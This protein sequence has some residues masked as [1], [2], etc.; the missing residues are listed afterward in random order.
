MRSRVLLVLLLLFGISMQSR[1]QANPL[2]SPYSNSVFKPQIFTASGQTGTVIQLNGLVSPSS[3]VGSSFASLTATLTGTSL[4]TVTFAIQGSS[5]NG[6]TF[7]PLPI[8]LVASPLSPPSLTVTATANGLYQVNSGGLTHVRVVTSGTFT[9]TS[10]NLTLTGSPNALMSRSSSGGSGGATTPATTL[11]L[12]GLGAVNGVGDATPGVDY[13]IPSGNIATATAFAA[14]PHG[15][16]AGEASNTFD[17]SGN[18]TN[19]TAVGG[20]PGGSDTEVQ[21]N[22]LG[23]FGVD[24][25]FRNNAATHNTTSGGLNSTFD[26]DAFNTANNGIA[27]LQA[28]GVTDIMVPSGSTS[29]ENGVTATTVPGTHLQ[30]RTPGGILDYY[31]NTPGSQANS[32]T[33]WCA[34]DQPNTIEIQSRCHQLVALWSDA[35][36][37]VVGTPTVHVADQVIATA[38]GQGIHQARNTMFNCFTDD[39]CG[40]DYLYLKTRAAALAAASE[41]SVLSSRQGTEGYAGAIY[42][43]LSS[44]STATGSVVTL[45]AT[46]LA[47]STNLVDL[48]TNIDSGIMTG[49][50][51]SPGGMVPTSVTTSTSHAL[52]TGFGFLSASCGANE[53]RNNP[54]PATCP[55]TVGT[56]S[57]VT[58]FGSF[59]T[60]TKV[61]VGDFFNFECAKATTVA[62]GNITLMLS[63]SHPANTPIYQGVGTCDILIEGNGNSP[64]NASASGTF[65]TF[66]IMGA[67]SAN[68]WDVIY[69]MKN[70]QNGLI[71]I[72]IPA[73]QSASITSASQTG[74]TVTLTGAGLGFLN[75]YSPLAGQSICVSGVS[76]SAFNICGITGAVVTNAGLTLTYTVGTSATITGTGGVINVGQT[77]APTVNGFANY[78]IKCGAFVT[79][80]NGVTF[81][82]TS[83]DGSAQVAYNDCPWTPG[84]SVQDP[85]NI[86]QT[87]LGSRVS[88][89]ADTPPTLFGANTL[90]LWTGAHGAFSGGSFL[91]MNVETADPIGAF[92]NY[93][94]TFQAHTGIL[95]ADHGMG[96]LINMLH[97]PINTDPGKGSLGGA[98]A[99]IGLFEGG[100]FQTNYDLFELETN[101]GGEGL[102][103]WDVT[104]STLSLLGTAAAP[105]FKVGG[106]IS[107]SNFFIPQSPFSFLPN[108]FSASNLTGYTSFS[109]ALVG[110]SD[111]LVEA[112]GYFAN[113]VYAGSQGYFDLELFPT[114]TPGTTTYCY[115]MTST[116]AFAGGGTGETLPSAPIC[117]T[118]GPTTL[119]GGANIVVEGVAQGGSNGARVYRTSGPGGAGLICSFAA[120]ANNCTDTEQTAGAAPPTVDT[121]GRFFLSGSQSLTR[122]EG[123][124]G[125]AVLAY[126]GAAPATNNIAAYDADGNAYDSGVNISAIGGGGGS[127]PATPLVLK[128]ANT[129][130]VSV[131]AT[132]GTDYVIPSGNITG[133]AS[134]STVCPLQNANSICIV[135]APYNAST[136]GATTTTTTATTT[137][138]ATTVAVASTSTFVAGNG[139]YIAGAGATGANYVGPVATIVDATHLTLGAATSTTV[140]SGT[141][142]QHD[143]TGAFQ[144]AITALA[145]TGG[146]IQIPDGT[147]LVNG[148]L[149]D[150]SGANAV[151][152]MPPVALLSAPSPS[153]TMQG[154]TRPVGTGDLGGA[155]IKTSQNSGNFLGG[156]ISSGPFGG[157]IAT[158]VSLKNLRFRSAST[159]PCL[160]MV[161][162]TF[163][164]TLSADDVWIDSAAPA[165]PSCATGAGIYFSTLSNDVEINIPSLTVVGFY[166]LARFGEHTHVGRVDGANSHLGY[167]FDAEPGTD[168]THSTWGNTISVGYLWCQLCDYLIS[169]GVSQTTVNIQVADAEV[170]TA[171]VIND[172]SNILR[173]VV[174]VNVPYADGRSTSTPTSI[175][176]SGGTGLRV[177]NLKTV[178]TPTIAATCTVTGSINTI[179]EGVPVQVPICGVAPSPPLENWLANETS[180]TTIANT[181][182]GGNPATATNVT[183]GSTAGF[184][185]N[186][187][188]YNGT[189]SFAF[190]TNFTNT[191]FDGSTP[192]SISTWVYSTMGVGTSGRLMSTLDTSTTPVPGWDLSLIGAASTDTIS[193]DLINNISTNLISIQTST[194]LSLNAI[195]HIC[196]NVDGSKTAAGVHIYIDGSLAAING[197]MTTDTLTGSSASPVPVALGALH[198][199]AAAASFFQGSMGY[200]R[201][202]NSVVSCPAINAAGPI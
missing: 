95:D 134:S 57:G 2:A 147:Y 138:G 42:T 37:D 182:N 27:T 100:G 13:T 123:S 89:I 60:T 142:V 157:F 72:P 169:A 188:Q 148:P 160:V 125:N 8:Y 192:F 94:G 5:D 176:Q 202:Y 43:V 120:P 79:H 91:G 149:Q 128:G 24:H 161:N 197:S 183:R 189:S 41:G 44:S 195:H 132:P 65:P 17:A 82:A 50:V 16:S 38:Y 28:L 162:G 19:C 35:G 11:L 164:S 23:D 193:F 22:R 63:Y 170:T 178:P 194:T 136:A 102:L 34:V 83:G 191:N 92:V 62:G 181:A 141:T 18:A 67:R 12:K 70:G 7:F 198:N 152:T 107:G 99:H 15:C 87:F 97:A 159:N 58:G 140:A 155:I 114:F 74:T 85:N 108:Q 139:I 167:I 118:N 47:N 130:G 126:T 166:A 68:A 31:Y 78:A 29:T 98:F 25:L 153:I 177:F 56:V 40:G 45:N 104:N 165:T 179:L 49:T 61:A 71:T 163:F 80:I 69:P 180:G 187:A 186:I 54:Q 77:G 200:S 9:A 135:S 64:I 154:F 51:S 185:G 199:G 10:V 75:H 6:V 201:V 174:H 1:A 39:D 143:E 158:N 36:E 151:L 171:A 86:A 168:P 172:P 26:A 32:I 110:R 14:S 173:G 96:T 119:T 190:A 146:T 131:A 59:N 122:V 184:P 137:A 53:V 113:T 111:A 129:L 103:N 117:L 88:W 116:T 76:N 66:P 109:N 144:A 93:G 127:I 124:T 46:G 90:N 133:T 115:V 73:P 106:T 101:S 30:L 52:S 84:H 105:T 145:T 20:S 48:S 156:F 150:T 81:N 33:D 21:V 196:V 55:F 121:T 3:T 112:G 4:T 175:V